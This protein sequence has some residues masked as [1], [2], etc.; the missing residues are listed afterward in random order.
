MVSQTLAIHFG[1]NWA[2]QRPGLGFDIVS[3]IVALA[4]HSPLLFIR[5]DAK[6]K[7]EDNPKNRLVQ[8]KM[9]DEMPKKEVVPPPPPPPVEKPKSTFLKKI[10]HLAR[11]EPPPPPPP[12]IEQ[13]APVPQKLQDA[14]RPL[15]LQ[16]KLDLPKVQP[17]LQTKTGFT[18]TA[19][20]KLVEQKKLAMAGPIGI[21]P[22]SAQR[23]GTVADP[24]KIKN[25][26]GS[27]RIA[28]N[29]KLNAIGGGPALAGAPAAALE[30]HTGRASAEKFSAPLTQ[31]TDKG[32]IGAVTA[33][34]L[35][36][37]PNMGLRDTVIA[38]DAPAA[39]IG[40]GKAGGLPGGVPGGVAG[41]IGTRQNAGHYDPAGVAG[42][43]A[44]GVRGGLIDGGARTGA[45]MAAGRVVGKKSMFTITGPLKDRRILRQ[46]TPE[47]PAWAQ[48]QGI[49][50]SVVLEFTVTAAGDVKTTVLVRR[51]SGY[52]KL[53]ETAIKAL[54]QWKFVPLSDENREE[55]GLIT[56]NY[57]LD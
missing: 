50:A 13:K 28:S 41:G 17:K 52:P 57:T 49:E 11:R 4:L 36:A 20:P 24:K 42:A 25:D 21:A 15:Q 51:T 18:T 48:A 38:R 45:P 37:G 31:R 53:D 35:A 40:G 12:P 43:P 10:I 33:N 30:I 6:K 27:F 39:M 54:R 14:P 46:V 5:F 2:D 29:E 32:H 26:K 3:L 16:P 1:Q 44:G 19:D 47:Y 34:G 7:A 8:V 9:L 55:V 22:L 23:L 56:F